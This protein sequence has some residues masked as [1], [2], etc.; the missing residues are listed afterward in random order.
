MKRII[1]ISLILTFVWVCKK[2]DPKLSSSWSDYQG[3]MNWYD[4]KNKCASL[5]MRLPS[6]AELI[7][8]YETKVTES[9]KKD[10][11]DYWTSDYYFEEEEEYVI[12]R[13]AYSFL[14]DAGFVIS[15]F[16]YYIANVRCIR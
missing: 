13:S 3:G 2:I 14:V 6:R 16:R 4:A 9:W 12:R 10:G 7:T 8:A 15:Y 1:A 11:L 5:G